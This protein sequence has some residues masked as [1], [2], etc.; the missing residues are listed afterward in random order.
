[1]NYNNMEIITVA[2][3]ATKIHEKLNGEYHSGIR[4]NGVDFVLCDPDDEETLEEI[5][6]T[7]GGWWGVK[8]IEMGFDSSDLILGVDYYGGG[9]ARILQLWSG[10]ES[11]NPVEM[12]LETILESVECSEIIHR[13][14]KVLVEWL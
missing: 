9:C 14:S 11:F 13:T 4:F 12:I 8:K 2:E 6:H 3:M 1:M 7:A 10:C 5:Y